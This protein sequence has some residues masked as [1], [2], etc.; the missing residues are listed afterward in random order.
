MKKRIIKIFKIVIAII[1]LLSIVLI[2]GLYFFQE[3][4]IFFP[5]KTEKNYQY[6]FQQNFKELKIKTSDGKLLNA[7]LFKAD[8]TKGLI[9]YLHGNAG[10]LKS[11]GYVAKS[12]TDLNYDV[13]ILDY[14]GFGKSEGRI[15][16]EKQLFEDTQK[17]YNEMKNI[18]NEQDITVLGYSIG[19][20]LAAKLASENNPNRLI[21]QAP[22]Y[23]F[24]YLVG[25]QYHFPTFMLKYKLF[26]NKFLKHCKCPIVIFHGDEDS[27]INHNSSV[28]LK[29]ELPDKIRLIILKG[30]PHNG[31]TD[32]Q[33]YKKELK[34]ILI[35]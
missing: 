17:A 7:L 15:S 30:Q 33:D 6:E 22:Y 11:W 5:Q 13:F 16:G 26:T 35:E 3:K 1:I 18:Y 23:S 31:I 2:A 34:T 10:S 28:K 27:V 20:G 25:H 24:K 14:R 19:T 21:L 8:T 32:N 4:L 12:Y 29:E 9:F